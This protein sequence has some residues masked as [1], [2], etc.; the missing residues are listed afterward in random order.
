MRGFP[1]AHKLGLR[2]DSGI[3]NARHEAINDNG[4][5]SARPR[6]LEAIAADFD[7][8]GG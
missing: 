2:D 8:L 5:R 3:V 4:R 1:A 6:R 7:A